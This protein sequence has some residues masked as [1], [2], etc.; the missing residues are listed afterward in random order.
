MFN[1]FNPF[2]SDEGIDEFI[3]GFAP[4]VSEIS[5]SKAAAI[6]DHGWVST[7]S[8]SGV[9]DRRAWAGCRRRHGDQDRPWAMA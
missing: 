5:P 7:L 6:R 3:A 2:E 8:L 9:V 1:P 4:N